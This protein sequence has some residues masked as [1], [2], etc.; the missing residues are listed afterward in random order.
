MCE[1]KE[2]TAIAATGF[3]RIGAA[4]HI[5]NMRC[6]TQSNTGPTGHADVAM[7]NSKP[8]DD[9]RLLQSLALLQSSRKQLIACQQAEA[10]AVAA[11]KQAK[12]KAAN[13]LTQLQAWRHQQR[14]EGSSCNQHGSAS[15]SSSS[16]RSSSSSSSSSSSILT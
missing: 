11:T 10:V 12:L 2:Q 6:F 13:M 4:K 15:S 7:A 3:A 9:A 16:S 14:R 8:C 1:Q 5:T